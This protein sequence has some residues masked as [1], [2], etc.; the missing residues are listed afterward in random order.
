MAAILAGGLAGADLPADIPEAPPA[1][2]ILKAA[3]QYG[4]TALEVFDSLPWFKPAESWKRWRAFV[5]AVYGLPMDAEEFRIY[6]ECTGRQEPTTEEQREADLISGRRSGKTAI[7]AFLSSYEACYRDYTPYLQ[8]GERVYIPIIAADKKGS[9]NAANYILAFLNRPAFRGLVDAKTTEKPASVSTVVHFLYEPVTI[10]VFTSSYRT[11]RG[12]AIPVWLGD[13]I[14]FWRTGDDAANPDR[15]IKKAVEGGM[16]QIPNAK[17][18]LLSSPY[19]QDGV[20]WDQYERYYPLKERKKPDG[21]TELAYDAETEARAREDRVLVWKPPFP[22]TLF[23]NPDPI[24][25]QAVAEEFR[26]D[27]VGAAAEYGG[28]F[29]TDVSDYI[30]REV[31][32]DCTNEGITDIGPCALGPDTKREERFNYH[33]FVDT[34]GGSQDAFT[35]SIA[36]WDQVRKKAVQDFLRVWLAPFKPGQVVKEA[37][38]DLKRYR[39]SHVTGDAYAGEWPRERFAENHVGYVVSERTKHDIYKALMPGLNSR[40]VLLLEHEYQRKELIGLRRRVTPLGK[41]II[42]HAQGGHDD[43][44]NSGA[45]ALLLAYDEGQWMQPPAEEVPEPET[46]AEIQRREIAEMVK[47]LQESR[48]NQDFDEWQE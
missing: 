22:S 3:R 41:D 23:M 34:S 42:D 28:N 46:T 43:A 27:P 29:R 9:R 48:T 10:E 40:D 20:L 1:T 37:C 21:S 11:S 5:A 14:A 31:V 15:E 4:V 24:V 47:Q 32:R 36:H 35:V 17:T 39:L 12:Y 7:D 18:F 38:A 13:E 30:S 44:I 45:G 2:A 33:A 6:R 8:P 26:K 25:A 19:G 16:V